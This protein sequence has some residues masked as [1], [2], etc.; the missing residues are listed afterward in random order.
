M[1]KTLPVILC[2]I[3]HIAAAQNEAKLHGTWEGKINV[4]ITMRV[5]FRF[6]DSAGHLIAFTDSPDQGVKNIPCSNVR[7]NGDSIYLEVPSAHGSYSGRFTCDSAISGQLLQGTA[8]ALNI[9][10]VTAIEV[11]YRPQTPVPPFAYRS[12]DIEYD[13][14][15]KT[16]HYGATLTI[17][18]GKGPFPAVVLI[19]GS[20]AQNRDEEIAGHKPFAVLADYLSN[21]GIMVLR[22]DDRGMGKTSRG[23]ETATTLDFA[24]D[25]SVSLDYLKSRPEAN[26]KKLGLMGHS[27]GGLIAPMLAAGRNDIGFI[28]LLAGPGQKTITL[29]EEQN[30]ALRAAVGIKPGAIAAYTSIYRDMIT[31][32]VQAPDITAAEKEATARFAKWRD[33]TNK[34]Y[35]LVTCGV[36]NDS[37]AQNFV[38]SFT[39]AT[40]SPWMRYFIQANPQVYLEKLHCK[41]LALNGSKDLQVIAKTN[42]P[43]IEAALKKSKSPSYEVKEIP[44]LNHLFQSCKKCTV[45]EYGELT[46]TFS[47]TALAIIGDWLSKNVQ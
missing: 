13:S 34:N 18:P 9:R 33:S 11:L 46:E 47:P 39:A 5:V 3:T 15:D 36:Y 16:M 40:Y 26:P 32:I 12:E 2:L 17:P 29:L 20:G 31:H 8:I 7:V 38:R 1:K 23:P 10:K 43:A 28:I 4:G 6:E 44:G 19:T 14:K 25:V 35:V 22:V 42:L 45:Q 24:G 30:A 37:T 21:R 41:V 27:E